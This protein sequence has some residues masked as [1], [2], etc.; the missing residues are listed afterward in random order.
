MNEETFL[1]V[2][3]AT[4]VSSA[5]GKYAKAVFAAVTAGKDSDKTNLCDS[6]F[7]VAVY[8]TRMFEKEMPALTEVQTQDPAGKTT[9]NKS[10]A[11]VLSSLG[12]A[13]ALL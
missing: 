1:K 12:V 11:F 6:T 10:N 9:D 5:Y 8:A 4:E 3:R 2:V 7:P 13:A